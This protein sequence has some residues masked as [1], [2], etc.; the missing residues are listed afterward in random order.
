M[1]SY[2]RAAGITCYSSDRAIPAM[3]RQKR[4]FSARH[5]LTGELPDVGTQELLLCGL[6]RA[7][8]PAVPAGKARL[9]G[10]AIAFSVG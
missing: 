10:A 8:G 6:I 4:S 5:R 7:P 1:Q 2:G 9:Q 3:N